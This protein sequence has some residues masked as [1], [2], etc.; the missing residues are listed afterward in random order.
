MSQS[1]EREIIDLLRSVMYSSAASESETG[2]QFY[3]ELEQLAKKLGEY[4]G[5]P[6]DKTSNRLIALSQK[7]WG[8][9]GRH[10]YRIAHMN[11]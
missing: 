11:D 8:M 10:Y 5:V 4:D 9:K 7:V 2:D 3:D 6:Y 1:K